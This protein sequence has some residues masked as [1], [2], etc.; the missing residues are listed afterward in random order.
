M[1][2]F[3]KWAPL[4]AALG[5]VAVFTHFGADSSNSFG[6]LRVTVVDSFSGFQ[7]PCTVALVNSARETIVD[8]RSFAHNEESN[9]C[10]L[11]HGMAAGLHRSFE[12][13]LSGCERV[14]Y[15]RWQRR[16]ALA[17]AQEFVA[18][19]LQEQA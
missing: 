7:T 16:G 19:F 11:D 15:E 3:P 13:D 5:S 6:T 17:R 8:N 12:L 2:I 4:A 18:S 9:V 14:V 10:L 1:R